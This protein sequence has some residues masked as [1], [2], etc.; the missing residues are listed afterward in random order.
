LQLEELN[1]NKN[2]E[3]IQCLNDANKSLQNQL[4]KLQHKINRGNQ[5]YGKRIF[6]LER[7]LRN[8]NKDYLFALKELERNK[9]K[10]PL[11][12]NEDFVIQNISLIK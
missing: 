6:N 4:E 3:E 9:I 12:S 11:P 5:K 2:E 10:A 7:Q 1:Q 8:R